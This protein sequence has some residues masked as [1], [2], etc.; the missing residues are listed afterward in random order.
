TYCGACDF[1]SVRNVDYHVEGAKGG[2]HR[3]G[4]ISRW[5]ELAVPSAEDGLPAWETRTFRE[6]RARVAARRAARIG[7]P[8]TR[9]APVDAAPLPATLGGAAAAPPEDDGRDGEGNAEEWLGAV[10]SS[11]APDAAAAPPVARA[12]LRY[13]KVGPAR[14][15]GTRELGNVFLR[16]A[17]RAVLPI[18]FSHGHH[19]LPRLP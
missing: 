10:P 16:A 5:A 15:I 14:F 12:R 2:E 18:A 7:V 6:L 9:P 19:P 17:R 1:E 3:G 8:A 11:L 13:R 4:M